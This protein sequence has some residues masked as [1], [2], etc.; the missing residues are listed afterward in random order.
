MAS[1]GENCGA[2][3]LCDSQQA[4]ELAKDGHLGPKLA[5]IA[6]KH[7]SSESFGASSEYIAFLVEYRRAQEREA[8]LDFGYAHVP[9]KRPSHRTHP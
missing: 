7:T 2:N 1:P 8:E 9:S 5:F 6:S 3:D 4:Y